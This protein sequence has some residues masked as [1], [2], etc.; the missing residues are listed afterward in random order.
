MQEDDRAQRRQKWA[1]L[2]FSI[3]GSLLASPPGHGELKAAIGDLA[4]RTWRHPRTGEPT[5]FGHSTIERWYYTARANEGDPVGAL[6]RQVRKDRGQSPS[7]SDEL[8]TALKTQHTDHP[9]WSYALHTD[10]LCALVEIGELGSVPS[11]STVRR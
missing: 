2:R 4:A 7:V 3:I 1:Q 5:R 10:N 6:R 11:A 9:S 8:V